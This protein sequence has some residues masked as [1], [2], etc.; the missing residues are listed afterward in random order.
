MGCTVLPYFF[1]LEGL[2]ELEVSR[3]IVFS[4]G[5]TA[6]GII[7]SVLLLNEPVSFSMITGM[8]V[9]FF[10]IWIAQR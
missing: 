4:C 3:A 2:R 8:A 7:F 5:I 6:F 10:S 9:I 1:W